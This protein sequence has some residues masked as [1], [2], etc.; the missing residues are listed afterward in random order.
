M[1]DGYTV[2][3]MRD[4]TTTRTIAIFMGV[5]ASRNFAVRQSCLC[6]RKP[7]GNSALLAPASAVGVMSFKQTDLSARGTITPHILVSTCL[8]AAKI[9]LPEAMPPE[10]RIIS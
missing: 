10:R 4:I 3:P 2:L 9:Q 7:P 5:R 1:P 6:A 8:N